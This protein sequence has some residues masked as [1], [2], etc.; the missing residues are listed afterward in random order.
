[1]R[2]GH[3]RPSV[4]LVASRRALLV[5]LGACAIDDPLQNG[6]D[7]LAIPFV[8]LPPAVIAADAD[9]VKAFVGRY[10]YAGGA[11]EREALAKAID[12]LVAKMNRLVRGIAR[13]KLT[14]T[15]PVETSL[16]ITANARALTV[17]FGERPFTAPL[18]GRP[19]TVKVV[20]GDEM[21]LHYGITENEIRQVFA[22]DEKGQVNTFQ[23]HDE[24]VV[25]RARVY[26]AQLPADLI[27]ELTYDRV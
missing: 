14:E 21:S 1:M 16:R 5:G 10:T 2:S 25:R 15:N 9:A 23:R 17:A 11:D 24:R 19:I 7:R 8:R 12:A 4:G 3:E 20:T 13:S 18:D 27:Y 26:A 6:S 22:G